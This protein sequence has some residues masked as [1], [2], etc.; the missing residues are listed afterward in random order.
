MTITS[1]LRIENPLVDQRP[2]QAT[3]SPFRIDT[4]RHAGLTTTVPRELVHR[5]ANAEVMLTGWDR[6]DDTR[7]NVR[8]QWPRSHSFFTPINGVYYDPL[9]AAETIRQIAPL[10]CH[11]EFGVPFG[12]QFLL[13]QLDLTVHPEQLPMYQ[14]PASLDLEVTCTDVKMRGRRLSGLCY[15]TAVLR[16]GQL[17]ATGRLSLTLIAP[18]VY[19]RLRPERV[20]SSEHRPL[21]LTAPVAPQSVGR[22]SPADVVLSPTEE[23]DLWQLRVDTRHPVLFD[24]PVDHVP[25]MVLLEAVRQGATAVLG[26][27]SFLPLSITSEFSSYVELDEPC[28][29]GARRLPADAPGGAEA[30]EVTGHQHGE[31]AFIATV[32]AAT[33]G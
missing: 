8:A 4:L 31:R 5:A 13:E 14:V 25:G 22:T 23:T 15:E 26:D 17:V 21:P 1:T 19:R 16:E 32:T 11:A 20:F 18:S 28:L 27:S 6:L 10:L 3:S 7:F 30:V 24:H 12:H 2:V 9:M 29:I 33:H